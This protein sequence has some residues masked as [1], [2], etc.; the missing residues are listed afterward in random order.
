MQY[1]SRY[2]RLTQDGVKLCVIPSLISRTVYS[3]K[4]DQKSVIIH[5]QLNVI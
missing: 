1:Y 4:G 3:S 5:H 2:S